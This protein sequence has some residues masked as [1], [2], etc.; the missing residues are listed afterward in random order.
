MCSIAR[1]GI[2]GNNQFTGGNVE[3]QTRLERAERGLGV[4]VL[5]W[6]STERVPG[7]Q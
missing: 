1:A 5:R 4:T 7:W 2:R 3:E 6:A